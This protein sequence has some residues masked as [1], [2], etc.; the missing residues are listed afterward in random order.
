MTIR[1]YWR[2]SSRL[3]VNET[4]KPAARIGR[5]ILLTLKASIWAVI[6]V[7]IFAPRMT[8]TLCDVDIRPAEINPTSSTVVIDDDWMIAVTAAPVNAPM[9]R[10][11]V[12][13][14]SMIFR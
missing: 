5:A 3:A 8:A 13:L 14:A 7:P 10:L 2:H 9:N 11:R 1:P 12:I 6:V 4:K